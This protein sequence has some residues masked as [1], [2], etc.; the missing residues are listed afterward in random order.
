M[1]KIA[2]CTLAAAGLFGLASCSSDDAPVLGGDGVNITVK[3]PRGLNTRASF[4]DGDAADCVELDN[5]QW[6]V[7]EIVDN[8]SV[9]V[10]SGNKDGAFGSSQTEETVNIPLAKGKTYQVAFYADDKDNGFISYSDGVVSVNYADVPSNVAAQDAFIG[11]SEVFTVSGAYNGEVTLT[12]PFA[13]LNWG[14]DDLDAKVL[15]EVLRTL[16]ANVKVASGLYGSMNVI[17]G[18]VADPVTDVVFNEV[19]FS[20]LP[21]Q[22]FPVEGTPAYSLIAMNYL[23][24]GNG[25]IDCELTL[26]EGLSPVVVNAAPVQVNHRTN[27]YGSLLTAPGTFEIKVDSSFDEPANNV[28]IVTTAGEFAGAIAA[29]GNIEIPA[30]AVVNLEAALGTPADTPSVIVSKE[31]SIEVKGKLVCGTGGQIQVQAPLHITGSGSITGGIRGCFNVTEGGTLDAENVTFNST[32]AYRGGDVWN[33]GGGSMSFTNVT[34]NSNMASIYFQPATEEDTLTMTGC[35]VNNTSRNSIVNP[36][37]G[38]RVWSY[39]IRVQGGKA[40]LSDMTV[41]GIQ[42][43]V[44]VGRGAVCDIKSGTYT[45]NDS[46]P[47]KGDGFYALYVARDGVANVYGGNFSALRPAVFNG[48]EDNPQ[49]HYGFIN[50]YGGKYSSKGVNQSGADFT[51]P[52][53]YKYVPLTGEDPYKWEVVKE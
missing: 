12:R 44:A 9:K 32:E 29:G 10:F 2:Y 35:I 47:G 4:G 36:E 45:V 43:G 39:A 50:L 26:T 38:E 11:K 19:L 28:K 23:L 24:T 21:D 46:E 25:V 51:L 33:Q 30:N 16:K 17:S 27:I 15:T 22:A 41:N 18:D 13:Q 1:K 7:F 6:T 52:Q 3:L 40:V 42:G 5:L 48:N 31:T 49:D 53:G 8:N 20:S 14:T 37:T 34:F